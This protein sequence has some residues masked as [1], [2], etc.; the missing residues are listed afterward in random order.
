MSTSTPLRS[1]LAAVLLLGACTDG[2]TDVVVKDATMGGNA[3]SLVGAEHGAVYWSIATSDGQKRVAGGSLGA[4]PASGAE[5]GTASG[6]VV[7]SGDHVLMADDHA[8]VRAGLGIEPTTVASRTADAFGEDRDERALYLT[9]GRELGWTVDG[10]RGSTMLEKVT[11]C[12]RL[13]VTAKS[14]YIDADTSSGRQLLRVDRA[15]AA[16]Q[17]LRSST[18]LAELFPGGAVIGSA[19]RGRLVDADDGGVRWLVEERAAGAMKPTRAILVSVPVTGE[20]SVLLEHIGAVTAFFATPD[21]FYWQEG[22]AVLSA[23]TSGGSA[24][25]EAHVTGQVGAVADGFV[26]YV[27][28]SAIERLAVD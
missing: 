5:L 25:I 3:A 19:Y 28:G 17:T 1:T 27:N 21:G 4:L 15:T 13:I 10:T 2:S 14:V 26:Y 22:D 12:E 24:S 9:S 23:P 11:S 16:S 6:Q 7:Q 20:P 18:E 8:I